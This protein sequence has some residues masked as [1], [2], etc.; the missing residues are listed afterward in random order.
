MNVVVDRS[1]ETPGKLGFGGTKMLRRHPLAFTI[2]AV[3]LLS[4]YPAHAWAE[5]PVVDAAAPD[6]TVPAGD[7]TGAFSLPRIPL[8]LSLF[9]RDGYDDNSRTLG[10][11]QGTWFTDE[12]ITLSYNLSTLKTQLNLRSGAD[13]TYYPDQTGRR[14]R[15]NAYLDLSVTEN[16]SLRL[17]LDSSVYAA[18]RTE[19]DFSSD[20]GAENVRSN[21]CTTLDS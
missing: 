12:G 2:L 10:S 5:E 9:T 19:P 13:L 7:E 1:T 15:V 18:Y 8:S 4:F 14:N 17:K 16:I 21:Y 11:G 6:T 3:A 20:V